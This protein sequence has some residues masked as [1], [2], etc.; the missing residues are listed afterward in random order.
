MCV[1]PVEGWGLWVFVLRRFCAGCTRNFFF[2]SIMFP[3]SF[4]SGRFHITIRP[5]RCEHVVFFIHPFRGLVKQHFP[6][7]DPIAYKGTILVRSGSIACYQGYVYFR[8]NFCMPQSA[9]CVRFCFCRIVLLFENHCYF[10]F[11][12]TIIVVRQ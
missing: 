4:V 5:F 12:L 1:R 8:H 6:R 9:F 7:F 3:Y 2:L 10:H 11:F